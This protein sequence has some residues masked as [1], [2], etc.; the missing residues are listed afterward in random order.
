MAEGPLPTNMMRRRIVN[1]SGWQSMNEENAYHESGHA[2]MAVYVGALVRT[3]T[4]DPDWDDGPERHADIRVDWPLEEFSEQELCEKSIEVALAGPVAEML[5]NGE[6][7]HP[8][9]VGEWAAD[10][11][12]A[13]QTAGRLFPDQRKRLAYLEQVTRDVRRKLNHGRNWAA[14]AAIAD[15]LLAH[16]T[17]DGDDV[18]EVM[19]EWLG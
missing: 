14:L 10:W 16:E 13:W 8:A 4:I 11:N 17:L 5:Y 9:T 19:Q 3:V 1:G 6:Q 7:K 15:L 2:F 18:E 12:L